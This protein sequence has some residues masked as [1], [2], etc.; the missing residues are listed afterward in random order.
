[1]CSYVHVYIHVFFMYTY[2]ASLVIVLGDSEKFYYH[3]NS[4]KIISLYSIVSQ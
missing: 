2:I 4:T 1:M 3:D